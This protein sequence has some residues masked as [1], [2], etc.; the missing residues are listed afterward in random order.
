VG[1]NTKFNKGTT[2]Q[3]TGDSFQVSYGSGSVTGTEYTE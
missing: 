3:S 1:A 2:G